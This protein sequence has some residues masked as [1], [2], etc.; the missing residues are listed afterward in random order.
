MRCEKIWMAAS[1][2]LALGEV[3][4]FF[5]GKMSELWTGIAILSLG[6]ACAFYGYRKKILGYLFVFFG[7]MALAMYEASSRKDILADIY[8]YSSV[9]CEVLLEVEG[10]VEE[11]L[12][13]KGGRK[14][15][16]R[17]SIGSV[18]LRVE[19]TPKYGE[20]WPKI[21]DVWKC[22]GYLQRLQKDEYSRP[23]RFFA[24]AE[25]CG[26]ELYHRGV[27]TKFKDTLQ[28]VRENFSARLG[29]GTDDGNLGTDLARA[30]LL[31]ER[32]RIPRGVREDFV[33]SGTV[34]VFAVSGLHVMY[35]AEAV[36]MALSLCLF[37]RRFSGLIVIP[38]LW[39]YVMMIGA[40]PSAVRASTMASLYFLA[41]VFLRRPNAMIA[42]AITF[43]GVYALN[44]ALVFDVG[45]AFSFVVMLSLVIFVLKSEKLE[46]D[47]KSFLIP[48]VVAWAAGVPIAAHVF[49][50]ITPGG[51]LANVLLIPLA[52]LSVKIAL[53]AIIASF[54]SNFITIHLNNLCGLFTQAMALVS[55]VVA[56]LP[57]SDIEIEKWPLWA[58]VLWYLL[59]GLLYMTYR[60]YRAS[61]LF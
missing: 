25:G 4:G 36:V 33:A 44:P 2:A 43:I 35:I 30:I 10:P 12:G 23:R 26:G 7:G 53:T 5:S 40:P 34:H 48:A 32:S 9:P 57:F 60:R 8:S 29:L 39:L 59:W 55:K 56:W 54:V 1:G 16:F 6:S 51:I 61:R 42:W 50:R 11:K 38:I 3:C 13:K 24:S 28:R 49:G 45:C 19:M 41:P 21:G 27:K 46:C 58:S 15:V 47:L 52:G 20:S 22:S 14:A 37:P 18:K 31:G 17:S